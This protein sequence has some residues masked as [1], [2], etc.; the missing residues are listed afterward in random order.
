[1]CGESLA[2]AHAKAGDATIIAGYLG[3]SESFD[4]AL[5]VYA[6]GYADQVE[7]DYDT[8]RRAIRAGRFSI[9][10]PSALTSIR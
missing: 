3:S 9:D 6:F 2:R 1:M 7:E 8:F 5:R 10:M 4:E